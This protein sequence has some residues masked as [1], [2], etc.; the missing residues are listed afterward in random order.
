MS[1]DLSVQEVTVEL[2]GRTVLDR[3]SLDVPR[4]SFL[5]LLGQSGSGK[6]TTLN[7]VA[8]FLRQRS[9]RVS[10]D[11]VP[12]D[13][14][15]PAE[16][17]IGFVFQN[18][19]LFP[20]MTVAE[21]V[22]FPLQVRGVGRKE[23]TRLAEEYL[24][25]VQLSGMRSRRAAQL[26]GGQQQRV[27]LARALVFRPALLLLDEPLA[28]LD[29]QLRESM[30]VELQRIQREVGVTTVAVT[31]DQ[32]EALAISDRVAVMDAGRVVRCAGP[33]EI[34]QRPGSEFVARFLG[35]ANVLDVGADGTVAALRT[36]L[37]GH[38]GPGRRVMVRPERLHLERLDG[39]TGPGEATV[40][41]SVYQGTR[42]RTLVEL[43]GLAEPLVVS[44]PAGPDRPPTPGDRVSVRCD[45]ADLH[46][47]DP[48]TGH[49]TTDPSAGP[50]TA[51]DP[52]DARSIAPHPE[53]APA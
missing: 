6:S 1:V 12:I 40:V 17:G 44:V 38:P 9:G 52:A 19:A 31:H 41:E 51:P 26:S 34:Y 18:Y 25:L 20:Y 15:S 21:N 33:E 45:P 10:I 2:D 42:H 53:G 13:D 11:G 43:T 29:K 37:D 3:V 46:L 28:A 49:D 8:G 22:A 5:T 23:R 36:G 47:L 14:A 16:R 32:V 50:V 48:A 27:A 7:V 35:E 4:G 30:Q 39:T 24:D